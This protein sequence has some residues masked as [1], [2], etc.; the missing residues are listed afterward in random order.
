MILYVF[1]STK[2]VLWFSI[3]IIWHIEIHSER[4]TQ[5]TVLLLCI[6]N[7]ERWHNHNLFIYWCSSHRKHVARPAIE[8]RQRP[9]YDGGFWWKS[10]ELQPNKEVEEER[11]KMCYKTCLNNEQEEEIKMNGF[12]SLS[13]DTI[14]SGIVIKCEWPNRFHWCDT[15]NKNT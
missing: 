12:Y 7:S 11:E 15:S 6:N 4:D 5:H 2:W 10:F 9:R 3:R 14:Y 1:V 8:L 13:F